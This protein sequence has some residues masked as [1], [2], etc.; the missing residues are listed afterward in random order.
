MFEKIFERLH[1]DKTIWILAFLFALISI[2][3]VYSFIPILVA[4]HG[5]SP[6]THLIKHAIILSAGMFVMYYTHKLDAKYFSR[7]AQIMLWTSFVLLFLTLIV[8]N[9]V[10]GAKRWL[11]IPIINQGFQTS[12]F[13]KLAIIL[14]TSRMLV[15][16]KDLLN[17]FKEGIWPILWPILLTCALIFPQDF[18]TAAMLF[19]ICIMLLFVGRVPFR[20]VMAIIGGVVLLGTTVILFA[21]ANPGTIS[22]VDT[23]KNRVEAF[24]SGDDKEAAQLKTAQRAIANGG[25]FGVGP[26][27]GIF[28]KRTPQA[29]ADFYFAS[30][31][32]ELGLLGGGTLIFVFLLLL[33]RSFKIAVR[34]EKF[35]GAL[36][37]VGLS[38]SMT[39][40]AIINMAVP[41]EIVPVT[42][43]NMPMLGLGGTAILFTC[44]SFGIILSISRTVYQ[45]EPK[46]GNELKDEENGTKLSENLKY[47]A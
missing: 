33:Y 18:S 15:I 44:I 12:D 29:Y 4:Q 9:S 20:Y 39:L 34:T 45:E 43:Q 35:F 37:V 31:I 36:V 19:M 22:R 41:T 26:G 47:E 13:A 25:W 23:W 7:L 2:V 38:I 1:G 28:K 42:G 5:G 21:L 27:K 24:N 11:S 8:G 46:D 17:N 40:Q 10:N 14:Y 30:F 32:E 3:T 16:K 6:T